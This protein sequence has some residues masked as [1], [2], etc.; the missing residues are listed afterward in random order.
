MNIFWRL[1]KGRNNE[2]KKQGE[3]QSRYCLHEEYFADI[4]YSNK[5]KY[6]RLRLTDEVRSERPKRDLGLTW[7]WPGTDLRQIWD[8]PMRERWRFSALDKLVPDRRTDRRTDRLTPWAPDGAKN[9][10]ERY[11]K[12]FTSYINM[13][14]P[15]WPCIISSS[16]I[17]FRKKLWERKIFLTHWP[18]YLKSFTSYATTYDNLLTWLCIIFLAPSGAQGVTMSVS[19]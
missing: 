14:P 19:G 5:T 15:I 16:K 6:F 12:I 4:I 17:L 13:L 7:N 2:N 18:R 10:G 3:N 9:L 11:L 8:R 1:P